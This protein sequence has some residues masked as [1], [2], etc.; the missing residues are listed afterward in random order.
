MALEK[1]LTITKDGFNGSLVAKNAYW[2]VQKVL[3]DKALISAEVVAIVNGKVV[4]TISASFVPDMDG[5]NFIAQ[6]YDHLKTL[7]EFSGATDC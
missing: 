4:D 6:A 2:K 5:K 3:G 1:N 7:P